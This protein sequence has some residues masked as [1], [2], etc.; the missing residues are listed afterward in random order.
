MGKPRTL[1]NTVSTG[2]PLEDGVIAVSDV[3]GLQAALDAKASLQLLGGFGFR[4]RLIN[5]DMRID[6]RNSGAAVTTPTTGSLVYTVDRWGYYVTQ[7]SKF[8]VQQNAGAVT[9]PAG[10]VNYLGVTVGAAANVTVGA[11][12]LFLIGQRIEG[13]NFSDIGM[14]QSWAQP[15]ILS[16]WVRSSLTGTFGGSISNGSS[17]GSFP[18][19]YTVS[20]AN[21]WQQVTVS[22]PAYTAGTW[23]TNNNACIQVY[24]ALGVGSSMVGAAGSWSASNFF[25]ATGQVNLVTTNNATFYVTGVQLE[26]GSSAT[27]FERRSYGAELALCQRYYE[28]ASAANLWSGNTTSGSTYYVACKY[29]V[30]KRADVVPTFTDVGNSGFAAGVPTASIT[31]PDGFL[32]AKNSNSTVSGGYFQ[33]SW[34]SSAEL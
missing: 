2:G 34:V 7:A 26:A 9:P 10:F 30:A 14:G 19:S 21:T 17:N 16:F 32:A 5:G 1:A 27:S 13:L 23:L 29:Q 22:V 12:D 24:F 6:Q 25:G 3:T 28:V 4:N 8:T 20:A 31:K 18:F 11:S 33:F 15:M